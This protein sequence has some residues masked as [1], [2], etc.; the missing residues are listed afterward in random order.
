MTFK[1]SLKEIE[2]G[3]IVDLNPK[4]LEYEE[5]YAS[6]FGGA[7]ELIAASYR[8]WHSSIPPAT[9]LR[10]PEKASKKP[11]LKE[12]SEGA[13]KFARIC[14]LI[15]KPLKDFEPQFESCF[16]GEDMKGAIE[17][18]DCEIFEEKI[19]FTGVRRT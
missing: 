19:V 18:A 16:P 17:Q 12:P 11:L 4:P 2:N 13:R 6:T 5:L 3:F 9:P 7:M 14:G 15:G 1:V 10:V 8:Q